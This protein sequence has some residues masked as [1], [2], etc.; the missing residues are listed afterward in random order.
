[1]EWFSY[2]VAVILLISSVIS[3]WLVNKE[4]NKHQLKLKKLDMYEE[5]KRKSLEKFISASLNLH[6]NYSLGALEEYY[7]SI[8]FLYIYFKTVPS[9]I[10][11]LN[12]LKGSP[13]LFNEL[14]KIVQV[15]S[16]QI[17]KE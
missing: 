10:N 11:I 17:E 14:T 13:E 15:L 1:M 8:N 2:A 12:S 16:E 3:P 5:C 9:N 6:E 7:K 4:N